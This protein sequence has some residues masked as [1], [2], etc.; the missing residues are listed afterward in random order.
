[1]L[2]GALLAT[3][4]VAS[5]AWAQVPATPTQPGVIAGNGQITVTFTAPAS[6]GGD[7]ITGY[8][9][10]CAPIDSNIGIFAQASNTGA[11][12]PIVVTG[13]TN[14]AGYT[15]R[16][17][18]TNADG[19]SNESPNS[20]VV[21]V[22]APVAPAQ[23]V[24]TAGHAEISVA[25]SPP[26]NN[27]NRITSYTARCA[28]STGAPAA[29]TGAASPIL[30]TVLTN[31]ASYTCTVTATNAI[32]TSPPSPASNAVI[33]FV[34]APT[35]PTAPTAARGDSKISVSFGAP[36]DNGGSPI[37]S[38][39]ATCSGSGAPGTNAGAAS[40]VTVTGLTNGASYTCTVTATN[41]F[42]TSPPSPPTATVV[43]APVPDAPPQPN[44][45][46]N[47]GSITVSFSAPADNGN[48]ITEYTATCVSSDGGAP[49]AR[50]GAGSPITVIGLS[51][52][53]TYTCSVTATSAVGTGP[54][55]PPS[56]PAI[57]TTP[58]AAP[59]LR[60]AAPR[61]G[62]AIVSFTPNRNGGVDTSFVVACA[63]S[64]SGAPGLISGAG[65]PVIVPG[66]S[67]GKSYQCTVR[68]ANAI[69]VSD[70]SARSRAIIVGAPAAPVITHV[71]SGFAL[72]SK[73]P[74]DVTFNPGTS[75]GSA[76]SAYRATCRQ[77]VTGAAK[78]GTSL[79]SP[80]P[81]AG[82][83]TGHGYSCSVTAT[84]AR[85]TSAASN[86][87]HATVGTPSV[88]AIT[89]VLP[90]RSGVVL[91]FAAPANNG[92]SPVSYYQARCA[93]T[94]GGASSSPLELA[95]PIVIDNLTVGRTYRCTLAAVNLRGGGAPAIVG[96]LV[97]AAT[98]PAQICHGASGILA[99]TPGLQLTAAERQTFA[100]G[101]S[102]GTCA[103]PYVQRAKLFLSFRSPS[104]SCVTA[105]G[106][107]SNGSGTLTWVAPAGLGNSD[108][109][110][111]LK[112]VSTSGHTTLATLQGTVTSRSNLFSNARVSGIV[113]LSRGLSGTGSGGD[114][115][116][117]G[118]LSTFVVSAIS[119]T[120]A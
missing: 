46:P 51:E 4:L 113:I 115:P 101:A 32:G 55:S 29:N 66:L 41:S 68:A 30:I 61:N 96:P 120:I 67:N 108:T 36:A 73:A 81:I 111:Q 119:L 87:V 49:G 109:S 76:V 72:A 9:A 50:S 78:V 98:Q 82:L 3:C 91:T 100:L 62:S 25:F 33:P 6:N 20:Q 114:C 94:D 22:G 26:A 10:S 24:A 69:G 60:A 85:G 5:P 13:L 56:V 15:C 48:P 8:T 45:S 90:I 77:D 97:I 44:V 28:S 95:S 14:G 18:A 83:L 11:V 52:A 88:P 43:P 112:I 70:P 80:I 53:R 35:A 34:S 64:N 21:F 47:T 99:A 31:G 58:P 2:L 27:G 39:T 38:Y 37:T 40:P 17:H 92:G 71:V 86:S 63:S 89:H 84:N 104:I 79:R 59:I 65:S 42:G 93:S 102:L 16:V 105:E 23:P 107:S 7:P 12:A 74:L 57:P 19:A 103:G 106:T 75:N 116:A 118:R 110:I 117:S 54:P 1:V